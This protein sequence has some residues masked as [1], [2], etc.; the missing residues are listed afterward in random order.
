MN[1]WVSRNTTKYLPKVATHPN[2]VR[3]GTLFQYF[4]EAYVRGISFLKL[5]TFPELA[6]DINIPDGRIALWQDDTVVEETLIM[7]AED[8]AEEASSMFNFLVDFIRSN[9]VTV[10][11]ELEYGVFEVL[12]E[13][14]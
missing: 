10:K 9:G 3:V 13:P 12:N 11:G 5:S 1:A 7:C 14:A 4:R 6:V 8:R 2:G